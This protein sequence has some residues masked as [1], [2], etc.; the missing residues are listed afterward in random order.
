ML[1]K[2]R[3]WDEAHRAEDEAAAAIRT[4]ESVAFTSERR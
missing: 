3:Y 1:P 4:S 2:S